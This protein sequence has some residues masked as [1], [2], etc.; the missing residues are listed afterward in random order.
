MS[1]RKVKDNGE[2]RVKK[3]WRMVKTEG[4][5]IVVKLYTCIGRWSF[6]ISAGAST[7]LNEI[8]RGFL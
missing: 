7:T 2:K 6:R 3:K 4:V 8:F 1:G 5:D